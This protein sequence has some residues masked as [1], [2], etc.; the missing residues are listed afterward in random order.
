MLELKLSEQYLESCQSVYDVVYISFKRQ[1]HLPYTYWLLLKPVHLLLK[2]FLSVN[3]VGIYMNIYI[4]IQT[5]FASIH[6]VPSIC[7]SFQ[8]PTS[9]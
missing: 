4:I 3:F 2:A 1:W 9:K 8:E 6:T 7:G 5:G